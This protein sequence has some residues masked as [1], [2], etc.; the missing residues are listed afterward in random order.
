M[1]SVDLIVDLVSLASVSMSVRCFIQPRNFEISP[2]MY[3]VKEVVDLSLSIKAVFLPPCF[4]LLHHS[5]LEENIT[6]KYTHFHTTTSFK[7][8]VSP[9]PAIMQIPTIL[10]TIALAAT[11]L[12]SCPNGPYAKGSDCA[13]ACIGAQ[14]CSEHIDEVVRTAIYLSFEP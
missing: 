1:H 13:G 6:Y 8:R 4:S 3:G 11:A 12:G 10:T 2:Y 5:T 9:P 7:P 14:R